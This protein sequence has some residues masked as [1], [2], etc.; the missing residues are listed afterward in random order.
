MLH[1]GLW[2]WPPAAALLRLLGC[3][4]Q[5]LGRQLRP[6]V[7]LRLLQRLL[8]LAGI[9]SI[10][11]ALRVLDDLAGGR[12]GR[13]GV[14]GVDMWWVLCCSAVG[15]RWAKIMKQ[16]TPSNPVTGSPPGAVRSL[17]QQHSLPHAQRLPALPAPA[18][19]THRHV[20]QLGRLAE[21]LDVAQLVKVKVALALHRLH[22]ELELR[23]LSG[24]GTGNMA[25]WLLERVASAPR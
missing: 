11:N 10:Q 19:G 13:V 14:A 9:G 5:R 25:R 15:S 8:G 3:D 1:S 2:P 12:G 23:Q 16:H 20:L 18:P 24:G 22:L 17:L 7:L 6:I 4:R 21:D